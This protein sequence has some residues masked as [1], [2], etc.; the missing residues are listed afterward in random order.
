MTALIEAGDDQTVLRLYGSRPRLLHALAAV[1][2]F[3][4]SLALFYRIGIGD[5]GVWLGVSVLLGFVFVWGTLSYRAA[6]GSVVRVTDRHL[7]LPAPAVPAESERVLTPDEIQEVSRVVLHTRGERRPLCI[8][9]IELL[10]GDT[11]RLWPSMVATEALA[12]A[13]ERHMNISVGSRS[14]LLYQVGVALLL[15]LVLA[16]VA[17]VYYISSVG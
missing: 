11:L 15:V 16:G 2:T 8:L 5:P 10:N 14:G 12:R 17:Y 3:C 6:N 1:A 13:L 9:E 4:V 7:T